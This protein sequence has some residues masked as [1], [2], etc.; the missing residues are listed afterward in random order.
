MSRS[1]Y[2]TGLDRTAA[3][4]TPLSPLDF[5][6][7]AAQVHPRCIAVVHGEVRYD[8][9]TADRRCRRLASALAKRGVR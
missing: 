8:W 1:P 3:N 7:R 4:F 5:L 2:D 6:A 9:A